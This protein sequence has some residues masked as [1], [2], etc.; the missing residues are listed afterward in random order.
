MSKI[1]KGRLGKRILSQ[2]ESYIISHLFE[3]GHEKRQE[4]KHYILSALNLETRLAGA[5][6]DF[7]LS[8]VK[9][10]AGMTG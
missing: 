9:V 10:D 1:E 2:R 6:F 5:T 3:H 7:E 4:L 8:L